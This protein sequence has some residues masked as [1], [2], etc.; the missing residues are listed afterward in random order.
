M[1]SGVYFI[2]NKT[3]GHYYIGSSGSLRR[4]WI[5][6]LS[7]LRHCKHPSPY[8][9]NAWN[10]YGEV[11]FEFKIVECC[12]VDICLVREQFYLDHPTSKLYNSS[13]IASQTF[14][15]RKHTEKTKIAI[16]NANRGRKASDIA[17][18]RMSLARRGLVIGEKHGMSKLTKTN[19]I[20]IRTRLSNG[21]TGKNLAVEYGVTPATISRIKNAINWSNV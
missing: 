17:K 8:L 10:R 7:L 2:I 15:N 20:E 9:Q 4:R 1:N 13:L 5:K 11:S 3:N 6:H 19:V 21:E 16:G 18:S 12:N 14:L